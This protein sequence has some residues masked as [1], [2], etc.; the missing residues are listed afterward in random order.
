MRTFT[1]YLSE[2]HKLGDK[3]EDSNLL[4][5]LPADP[6]QR[7]EEIVKL[8]MNPPYNKS[9]EDAEMAMGLNGDRV[10]DQF[11]VPSSDAQARV[12]A[13]TSLS[14]AAPDLNDRMAQQAQKRA[15]ELS[16]SGRH[17]FAKNREVAVAADKFQEGKPASIADLTRINRERIPVADVISKAMEDP[18]TYRFYRGKDGR[19]KHSPFPDP[20]AGGVG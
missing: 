10:P 17:K 20:S 3:P 13:T 12:S 7:R 1:Q 11:D 18:I 16:D 14:S 2:M 5:S 4:R 8:W 15:R 9:R 6:H 19:I